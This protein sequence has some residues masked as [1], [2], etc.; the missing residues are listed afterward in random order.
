[1]PGRGPRRSRVCE[2]L[3]DGDELALG[4]ADGASERLVVE[5]A[6]EVDQGAG[7]GGD[8]DALVVG[9]VGRSRAVDSDAPVASRCGVGAP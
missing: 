8:G 7:G 2:D 4:F 1:M 9:G 3:R 5:L 6:G